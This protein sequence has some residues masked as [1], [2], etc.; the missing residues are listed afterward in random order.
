MGTKNDK[1][2][3]NIN[4]KIFITS[5]L[6][7]VIYEHLKYDNAVNNRCMTSKQSASV[8]RVT[9]IVYYRTKPKCARYVGMGRN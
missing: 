3:I 2:K 5:D 8:S 4:L 7:K 1:I 6:H 9:M